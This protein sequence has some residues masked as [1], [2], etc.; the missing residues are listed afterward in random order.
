MKAT[1]VQGH[2]HEKYPLLFD[3]GVPWE[4]K[5]GLLKPEKP[6]AKGKKK[7]KKGGKAER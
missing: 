1:V 4:Q 5:A 2:G 7:Q 3:R 6:A